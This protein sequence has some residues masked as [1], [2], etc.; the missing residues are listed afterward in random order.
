VKLEEDQFANLGSYNLAVHLPIDIS[1]QGWHLFGKRV[2]GYA[3]AQF[4]VEEK[5]SGSALRIQTEGETAL[6]KLGQDRPDIAQS[7]V[8]RVLAGQLPDF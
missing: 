2:A 3:P 7:N 6:L 8:G 4:G 1:R 5:L